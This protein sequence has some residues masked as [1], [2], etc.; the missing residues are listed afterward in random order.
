MTDI[1]LGPAV[2]IMESKQAIRVKTDEHGTMWIPKS[3]ISDDSEVYS[4]G[5]QGNLVVSEWWA[6]LNV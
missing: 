3:Q 4:L 1:S 6:E 2:C 5:D